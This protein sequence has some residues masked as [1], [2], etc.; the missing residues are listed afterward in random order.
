MANSIFVIAAGSLRV[1]SQQTWLNALSAPTF[2]S[3]QMGPTRT[4]V[5]PAASEE[6]AND[7]TLSF[8]LDGPATGNSNGGGVA[9]VVPSESQR[10]SGRMSHVLPE[11][12]VDTELVGVG[13]ILGDTA[14]YARRNFGCDAVAEAGGCVAFQIERSALEGLETSDPRAVV[15]LQKVL[16]RDLSQLQVQFLGPLQ[17]VTGLY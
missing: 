6:D 7:L 17:S 2:A 16:L 5:T 12:E 13:A 10:S 8:T 4:P 15:F 9:T 11:D 1:S 3:P 14:Y